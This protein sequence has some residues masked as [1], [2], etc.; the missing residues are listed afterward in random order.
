MALLS[1]AT[2]IMQRPLTTAGLLRY[3]ITRPDFWLYQHKDT[4]SQ[5]FARERHQ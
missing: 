3:L 1:F 2:T 4:A 5:E